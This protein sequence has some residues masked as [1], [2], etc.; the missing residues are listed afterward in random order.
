MTMLQWWM[1]VVGVIYL[2]LAGASLPFGTGPSASLA[3]IAFDLQYAQ[4]MEDYQFLGG[5]MY[6]VIGAALLYGSRDVRQNTLIVWTVIFMEL[7]RGLFGHAYL[8]VRGAPTWSYGPLLLLHLMIIATG[9]E[10]ARRSRTE[11]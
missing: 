2:F 4:R 3:G 9:L 8:L 6:G 7:V 1:R 11:P 10:F 5:L